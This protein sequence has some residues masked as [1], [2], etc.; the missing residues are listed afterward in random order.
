MG[1]RKRYHHDVA[2]P[3]FPLTQAIVIHRVNQILPQSTPLDPRS[4]LTTSTPP[5]RS[6]SPLSLS[7]REY[8]GAGISDPSLLL[9]P[10]DGDSLQESDLSDSHSE[11]PEPDSESSEAPPSTM[12]V[13]AVRKDLA[14]KRFFYDDEE[15]LKEVGKQLGKRHWKS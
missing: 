2:G 8:G 1:K 15:A 5:S 14:S 7:P 10:A 13:S 3:L 9:T 4:I 6:P 11:C 12:T